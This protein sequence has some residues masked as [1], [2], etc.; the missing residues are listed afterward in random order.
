M[1]VP[2]GYVYL[3]IP[4]SGAFMVLRYLLVLTHL[5]AG[6]DYEPPQ[7]DIKNA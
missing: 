7:A 4:L 5:I 1:R 3:I 6:R 2:V